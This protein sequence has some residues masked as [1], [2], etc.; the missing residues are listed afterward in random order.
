MRISQAAAQSG[1]SID[2][3]RYYERSGL[4]PAIARG[5]DGRRWFSGEAVEWLT[6]LASLRSTGMP[7][8]QMRRFAQLY[9]AGDASIPARRQMLLDH[10]AR[11]EARRAELDRCAALLTY[12]LDRYAEIEGT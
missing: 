12:K 7:M 4:L 2:T 6:L 11:L 10:Q 8:D 9:Q 5:E 3:I 1:L